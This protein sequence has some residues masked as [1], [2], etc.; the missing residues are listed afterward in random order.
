MNDISFDQILDDMQQ[1]QMDDFY[2]RYLDD[3]Q[4]KGGG[5][6][7]SDIRASDKVTKIYGCATMWHET[8]EEMMEMLKSIFRIDKVSTCCGHSDSRN[9]PSLPSPHTYVSEFDRTTRHAASR[10][11]TS[12][13]WTPTTTSGRLTSCS[14]TPSSL[15]TMTKR[16]RL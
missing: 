14:T 9:G 13:S 11:S 12:R 2:Q 5:G 4:E 6:R 3:G 8:K 1:D 16:S 10:R 15:E 7:K